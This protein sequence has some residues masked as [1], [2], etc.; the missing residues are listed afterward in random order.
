M[1][2]QTE[3]QGTPFQCKPLLLEALEEV[4]RSLF[5]HRDVQDP[6]GPTLSRLLSCLCSEPVTELQRFIPTPDV[7]IL[8]MLGGV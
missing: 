4:I 1:L 5:I 7:S 2:A 8:Y 6:A 3:I